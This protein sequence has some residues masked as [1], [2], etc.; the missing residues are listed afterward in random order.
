M[1][2]LSSISSKLIGSENEIFAVVVPI[3]TTQT[4][5]FAF[6]SGLTPSYEGALDM[7]IILCYIIT[8]G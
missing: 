6:V 2:I 1:Y 3:G 8:K 5:D 4:A 7:P